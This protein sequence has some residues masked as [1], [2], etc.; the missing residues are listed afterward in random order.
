[1]GADNRVYFGIFPNQVV[2]INSSI[3]YTDN[4]WHYAVGTFSGS[5]SALRLYVDGVLLTSNT[6]FNSA[7]AYSGYWKI[8]AG[9]L[10]GWPSTSPGSSY[11]L[12]D[13]GPAKV[14]NR[15]LTA[16]EILQNYNVDATRFGRTP[17]PYAVNKLTANTTYITDEFNEVD[18][19]PNKTP[20]SLLSTN[21]KNYLGELVE[22]IRKN[23]HWI[24]EQKSIASKWYCFQEVL[25]D[26]S[27]SKEKKLLE[28]NQ[29]IEQKVDDQVKAIIKEWPQTAKAYQ[30]N[31]L[32]YDINGKKIKQVLNF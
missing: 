3:T 11:F 31:S 30:Q 16:D 13:I 9:S 23:N 20:P 25:T 29:L 7:Q 12:G 19:N 22:V 26:S 28:A 15:A 4:V 21:R 6:Q 24:A 17:T 8:G 32:E 27:L 1:M 2:S 14:Y 18:Y 10:G 5:Q